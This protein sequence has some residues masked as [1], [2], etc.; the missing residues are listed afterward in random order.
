MKIT[1]ETLPSMGG[2]DAVTDVDVVVGHQ[3]Y[4]CGSVTHEVPYNSLQLSMAEAY[5]AKPKV[6]QPRPFEKESKALLWL[7]E[8]CLAREGVV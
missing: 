8:R 3:R 4:W 5:V 2:D 1:I 7:A 6:G